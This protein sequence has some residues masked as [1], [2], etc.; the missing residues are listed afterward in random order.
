[1]YL[2]TM[3]N[4]LQK[5]LAEL[6]KTLSHKEKRQPLL[7][8]IVCDWYMKKLNEKLPPLK[9]SKLKKSTKNGG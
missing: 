5:I 7:H 8:T 9:K 2:G 6:T 4:M 1:M 3:K